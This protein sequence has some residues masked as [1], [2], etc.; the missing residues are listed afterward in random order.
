MK[1]IC[2]TRRKGSSQQTAFKEGILFPL[3]MKLDTQIFLYLYSQTNSPVYP[4]S[5]GRLQ[6]MAFIVKQTIHLMNSVKI[7]VQRRYLKV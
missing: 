3:I 6:G 4:L 7:T 2:G 5:I 1:R